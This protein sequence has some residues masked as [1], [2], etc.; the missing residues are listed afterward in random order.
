MFTVSVAPS[1]KGSPSQSASK[2]NWSASSMASVISP[3][4]SVT[5]SK[6]S[7][8]ASSAALRADSMTPVMMPSSCIYSASS[9]ASSAFC[10]AMRRLNTMRA[11]NRL[12]SYSVIRAANRSSM[13]TG[14]ASGVM[15]AQSTSSTM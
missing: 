13:V 1:K 6:R 14:D 5:A 12:I 2:A 8:P 11:M 9:K 4:E 10:F 7:A 15:M 3:T